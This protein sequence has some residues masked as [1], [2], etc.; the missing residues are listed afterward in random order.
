MGSDKEIMSSKF[1]VPSFK[2]E[3]WFLQSPE[4]EAFL[5]ACDKETFRV[6]GSLFVVEELPVVGRY[7]YSPR[8][9][10][11]A[12]EHEA[13]NTEQGVQ[14]ILQECEERKCSWIR[15]EPGT[16][17][18]LRA[19]RKD[20]VTCHM[21]LVTT[22]APKD[23]QPREILVMDI[24]KDEEELLAAMK[25][26]VR[27]NIR[28]AEKRGVKVVVS[29][30]KR[31][32][33][34]FFELVRGTAARAGIRAHPQEHYEKLFETFDE[35]ML[36]LYSAEYQG[37]IIASNMVVFFEDFAIYLHGGSSN[38][39]RNVMAPFLLQWR[40]IQDAKKRG[41]A[42]YDLGGVATHNSQLVT[43]NLQPKT[44]C[45]KLVIQ[46][47]K[48]KAPNSKLQTP[49]SWEGITKFKTGFCPDAEP[50]C[51]PGTYDIVVKPW[52]YQLYRTLSGIKKIL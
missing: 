15:M 36:S 27:Y 48:S 34:K 8:G 39:H 9:P 1:Q 24:S 18:E 19:I 16:E 12:T 10:L 25:S 26:K 4:W 35:G 42:W 47:P 43:Q 32:R 51:F 28:L 3:Q 50:I 23:I 14:K 11:A 37:E 33:E 29:R 49:S 17:R 44:Q 30:E 22:A 7:A 21:S 41:C 2:I 31:Y 6:G 20:L 13:R 5:R 38:A 46:N 45:P 52:K 40:A